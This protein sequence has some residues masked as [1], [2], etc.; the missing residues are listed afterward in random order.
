M[1]YGLRAYDLFGAHAAQ[2][3]RRLDVLYLESA[4]FDRADREPVVSVF[5]AWSFPSET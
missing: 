4:A 1:E 2:A 3:L 5:L